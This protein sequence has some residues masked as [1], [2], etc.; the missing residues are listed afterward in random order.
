MIVTVAGTQAEDSRTDTITL[1]QTAWAK[2][3]V[4]RDSPAAVDDPVIITTRDGAPVMTGQVVTVQDSYRHHRL[5]VRP[6]VMV[7]MTARMVAPTTLQDMPLP[8]VLAAILGPHRVTVRPPLVSLR[9]P[10]WSTHQRPQLWAL[11]S[12]IR[13]VRWDRHPIAW[14]YSARDDEIQVAEPGDP[15][16]RME[17]VVDEPLFARG[18]A[19]EVSAVDRRIEAGDILNGAPVR[20]EKTCWTRRVKRTLAWV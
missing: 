20:Q 9:V 11:E 1:E 16:G 8:D 18:G 7:D 5:I 17:H 2:V 4:P 14:R 12:L 13:A 19:L 3:A 10:F 15:E 6:L